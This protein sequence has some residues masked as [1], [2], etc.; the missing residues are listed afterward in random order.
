MLVS[1]TN[2]RRPPVDYASLEDE[3]LIRLVAVGK[4]EAF[5]ALCAKYSTMIFGIAFNTFKDE[6]LAEDIRQD[7]YLKVW[8]KAGSYRSDQ[9]KVVTWIT[10]I[11]RYRAID[12]FRHRNIRPEG[13]SISWTEDWSLYPSAKNNVENEVELSEHNSYIRQAIS[14]LPARQ[15]EALSLAYFRGL[16][17]QE[18]AAELNEP[19]GTVKTRIRRAM[20]KLRQMLENEYL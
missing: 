11:T 10:S 7:V 20:Q 19:I 8:E 16:T 1:L 12:I 14:Q 18:V 3:T 9:G 17:Y 5:N 13:H 6:N 2:R 4:E 15:R